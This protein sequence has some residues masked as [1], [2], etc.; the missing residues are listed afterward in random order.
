MAHGTP[1][2]A[3]RASALPEVVGEA[4]LLFDPTS[5]EAIAAA[6]RRIWQDKG[7]REELRRRGLERAKQYTWA[8]TAGKTLE[9]YRNLSGGQAVRRGA[10]SEA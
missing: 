6:M 10:Y 8:E 4:G 3:A 1:V 5:V 7:L 2:L 9:V